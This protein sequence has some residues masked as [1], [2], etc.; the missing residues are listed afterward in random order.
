MLWLGLAF[1]LADALFVAF[2]V[3]RTKK[4]GEDLPPGHRLMIAAAIALGLVVL[5]VIALVGEVA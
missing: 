4:A 2:H 5:G 3:S 1:V